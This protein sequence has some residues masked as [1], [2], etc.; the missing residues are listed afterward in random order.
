MKDFFKDIGVWNIIQK[1]FTEPLTGTEL[2]ID[3]IKQLE[4]NRQ[5]NC[6]TL[7]YLIDVKTAKEVW[8]FLINSYGHGGEE[9]C[10]E[11][12]EKEVFDEV[13]TGR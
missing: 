11:E 12:E 3:A 7:Y 13:Y 10:D 9:I 1:G 2:S 8:K 6:K 5:L 4:R